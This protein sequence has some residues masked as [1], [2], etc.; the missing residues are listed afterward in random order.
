MLLDVPEVPEELAAVAAV[1]LELPEPVGPASF[2]VALPQPQLQRLATATMVAKRFIFQGTVLLGSGTA[3]TAPLQFPFSYAA[4]F[5]ECDEDRHPGCRSCAS[6]Q[7]LFGSYFTASGDRYRA[8]QSHE[9]G[10][11]TNMFM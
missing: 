11:L 9:R 6:A 7:R 2:G 5:S 4:R 3:T 10:V 1:E 8:L